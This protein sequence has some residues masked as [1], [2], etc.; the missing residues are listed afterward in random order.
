[1]VRLVE[2]MLVDSLST[3]LGHLAAAPLRGRL[4]VECFTVL[5]SVGER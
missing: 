5:T 3:N 2:A 4:F 1:M